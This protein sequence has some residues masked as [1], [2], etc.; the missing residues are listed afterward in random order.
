MIL[1][2]NDCYMHAN[3]RAVNDGL[4]SSTYV[5]TIQTIFSI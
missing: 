5:E 2:G 3:K 1:L 4:K